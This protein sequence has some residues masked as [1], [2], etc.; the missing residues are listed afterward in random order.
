MGEAKRLAIGLVDGGRVS[1]EWLSTLPGADKRNVKLLFN[2]LLM[3]IDSLPRGGVIKVE[4]SEEAGKADI[5]LEGHGNG[6]IIRDE[7]QEVLKGET[8]LHDLDGRISQI[9]YA[10]LLAGTLGGRVTANVDSEVS[11]ISFA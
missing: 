1:I 3:S 11:V 7:V 8:E 4:M 10:T 9:H 5:R 6:V 2:L